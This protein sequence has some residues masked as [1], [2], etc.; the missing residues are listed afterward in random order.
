MYIFTYR[1]FLSYLIKLREDYF[2]FVVNFWKNLVMI[3]AM[4]FSD[5]VIFVVF[6]CDRGKAKSTFSLKT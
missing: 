1:L 6:V 4:L 3:V 2:L 5:V